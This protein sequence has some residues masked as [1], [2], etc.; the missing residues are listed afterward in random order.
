VFGIFVCLS[1]FAIA[2]TNI[3]SAITSV[4][5]S[6]R[7]LDQTGT[8]I[9]NALVKS[10][11]A[12]FDVTPAVVH[13][14]QNGTFAVRVEPRRKYELTVEMAGFKT[15]LKTVDIGADKEFNAGDIVLPVGEVSISDPVMD[16]GSRLTTLM[17]RGITRQKHRY[18]RFDLAKLAQKSVK[19]TDH[20]SAAK[21]EGVPLADVLRY[22]DL[23]LGEKFNS[24]VAS[25]YVTAEPRDGYEAVFAWA[26]LDSTFMKKP[27]Y[28]VTKRDGKPLSH[29]DGPFE[30][31]VPIEKRS[32][33][34]VRQLAVL[35]IHQ[36]H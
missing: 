10:K 12:A 34:W 24:T 9:P 13:A 26:E 1:G 35:K 16:D 5:I 28:V 6:G 19:A 20:G 3:S 30:L 2:Q 27:V 4:R 29:E 8:L 32:E 11:V 31:L 17:I 14:D 36:A 23:P 15:I 21:F 22:V 33:R 18:F 7:I 25:Y